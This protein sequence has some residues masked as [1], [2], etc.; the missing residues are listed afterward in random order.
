MVTA[1]AA[2]SLD[3]ERLGA[4]KRRNSEERNPMTAQRHDDPLDDGGDGSVGACVQLALLL[5]ESCDPV[6]LEQLPFE[7]G[8]LN[9]ERAKHARE[10]AQELSAGSTR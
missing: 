5:G 7:V 6:V 1:V 10:I 2:P 9:P 8:F 3:A 4:V